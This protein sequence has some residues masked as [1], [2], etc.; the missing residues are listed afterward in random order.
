MLVAWINAPSAASILAMGHSGGHRGSIRCQSQWRWKHKMHCAES[1][2][3]VK[4]HF[5]CRLDLAKGC[6]KADEI[7]F[8]VVPARV[9]LEGISIWIT[10]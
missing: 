7:L 1:S 10:N 5:T 6:Q 4:V 8:L 2:G 9:F 3:G